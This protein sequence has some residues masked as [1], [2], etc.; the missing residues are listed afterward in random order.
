MLNRKDT[1]NWYLPNG[2]SIP[3][4]FIDGRRPADGRGSHLK[5]QS[6]QSTE[7]VWCFNRLLVEAVATKGLL[8]DDYTHQLFTRSPGTAK[9]DAVHVGQGDYEVDIG[10][11]MGMLGV[12]AGVL[13]LSAD[14]FGDDNL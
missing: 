2:D 11:H 9:D 7:V 6:K 4:S 12:L 8:P 5:R 14:S 13:A 3:R 10:M 1:L